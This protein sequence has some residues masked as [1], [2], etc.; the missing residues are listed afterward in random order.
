MLR[1]SPD[2]TRSQLNPRAEKQKVIRSSI[3]QTVKIED[4]T[5]SFFWINLTKVDNQLYL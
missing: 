5:P 3:I 1:Q 2:I 4:L